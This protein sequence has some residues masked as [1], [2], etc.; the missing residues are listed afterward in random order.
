MTVKEDFNPAWA[1]NTGNP[2]YSKKGMG[3]LHALAI[4]HTRRFYLVRWRNTCYFLD[5][6]VDQGS[7]SRSCLINGIV[8][9]RADFPQKRRH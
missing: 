1:G 9:A 2:A 8:Q 4:D 5:V 3:N 6:S 7:R